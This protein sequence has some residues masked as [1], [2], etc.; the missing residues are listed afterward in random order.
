V[1]WPI[2]AVTAPSDSLKKRSKK[3]MNLSN[4]GMKMI[5]EPKFIIV[6]KRTKAMRG[7]LI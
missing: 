1:A 7:S 6:E 5:I 4:R 2:K 3:W